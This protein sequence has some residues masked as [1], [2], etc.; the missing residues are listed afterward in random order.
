MILLILAT[1]ILASFPAQAKPADIRLCDV[2]ELAQVRLEPLRMDGRRF[3]GEVEIRQLSDFLIM[4]P[5]GTD[6][7]KSENETIVVPHQW[8]ESV[9]LRAG[10]YRVEGTILVHPDC[11]EESE[12]WLCVPVKRPVH[13]DVDVAEPRSP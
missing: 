1:G 3:C 8:P 11:F 10:L 9:P 2:T 6:L 12:E 4:L 7:P 5:P 13:F